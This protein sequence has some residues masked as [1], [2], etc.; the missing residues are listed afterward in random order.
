MILP[1]SKEAKAIKL[2]KL[3]QQLYSDLKNMSISSI[4]EV[5]ILEKENRDNQINKLLIANHAI[6][7]EFKELSLPK[8]PQAPGIVVPVANINNFSYFN[9]SLNIPLTNYEQILSYSSSCSDEFYYAA[10]RAHTN[11][12][13]AQLSKLS[14]QLGFPITDDSILRLVNGIRYKQPDQPI[15]VRAFDELPIPELEA[16]A[17]HFRSDIYIY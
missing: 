1:W 2:V 17:K 9:A 5:A 10:H 6:R 16:V 4:E 12:V 15:L 7:N 3:Q 14:E 11:L 13:K 8:L